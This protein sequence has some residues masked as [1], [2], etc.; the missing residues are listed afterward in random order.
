[1]NV[2]TMY[3][4]WRAVTDKIYSG[5]LTAEK[6]AKA[7]I[8]LLVENSISLRANN[9]KLLGVSFFIYDKDDYRANPEKP[10]GLGIVYMKPDQTKT[11]DIFM[12]QPYGEIEKYYSEKE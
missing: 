9:H 6:G 8:E 1:M 2:N 10:I 7:V 11:Q 12:V 4:N 3:K 5:E